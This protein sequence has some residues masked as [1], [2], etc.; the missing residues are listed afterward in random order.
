MTDENDINNYGNR[1]ARLRK[2]TDNSL[3][4]TREDLA[5]HLGKLHAPAK[6]KQKRSEKNKITEVEA[7]LKSPKLGEAEKFR[8]LMSLPSDT[9]FRKIDRRLLPDLFIKI[10]Q[11]WFKSSH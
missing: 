2:Y 1:Q 10:R 8:Y 5:Y 11:R 9:P 6:R 3:G 7:I 4:I